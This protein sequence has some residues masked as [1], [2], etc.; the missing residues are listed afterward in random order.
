M[1]ERRFFCQGDQL[2]RKRSEFFGPVPG[3]DDPFVQEQAVD[4][5]PPHQSV[6]TFGDIKFAFTFSVPH[7]LFLS[8]EYRVQV[9]P[10]G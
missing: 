9:H 6:V 10:E 8:G 7:R 1:M 5:V 4:H 2:L 3:G